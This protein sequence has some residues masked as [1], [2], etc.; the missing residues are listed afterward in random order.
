MGKFPPP[1][2]GYF[3]TYTVSLVEQRE[4]CKGRLSSETLLLLVVTVPAHK[5]LQIQGLILFLAV[6]GTN[7]LTWL[8]YSASNLGRS[9]AMGAGFAEDICPDTYVPPQ[10]DSLGRGKKLTAVEPQRPFLVSTAV[11]LITE[12]ITHT[13][14]LGVRIF[15]HYRFIPVNT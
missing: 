10:Q 3:T 7:L 12:L 2:V 1:Q 11:Y 4:A 13:P 14:T 9:L 6:Q 5:D 8:C 15:P